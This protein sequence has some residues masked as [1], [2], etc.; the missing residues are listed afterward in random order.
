M[1]ARGDRNRDSR[2][3]P[4]ATSIDGILQQVDELAALMRV[5]TRPAFDLERRLVMAIRQAI[6]LMATNRSEG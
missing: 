4:L 3:L 6:A 2:P 1:S 5:A